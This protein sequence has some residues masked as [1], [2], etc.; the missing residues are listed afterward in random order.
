[1]KARNVRFLIGTAIL[2]VLV[3]C[4]YT[5]TTTEEK[6]LVHEDTRCPDC[7]RELP[8]QAQASGECPYCLLENGTAQAPKKKNKKWDPGRIFDLSSYQTRK[9]LTALGITS[10]LIVFMSSILLFN[11]YYR[12]GSPRA[13]AYM[14][15]RCPYCKRKLRYRSNQI[16]HAALC[17]GCQFRLRFPSATKAPRATSI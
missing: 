12:L 9:G 17:P 11:K 5:L 10:G 6:T 14:H 7:G 3:W 1:M 4:F 16:G 2:L 13:Y 8:R 15:F